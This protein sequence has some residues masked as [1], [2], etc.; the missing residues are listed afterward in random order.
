MTI[1]Q[2]NAELLRELSIIAE[3]EGMLK[4]VLTFVKTLTPAKKTKVVASTKK[5]YKT[6]PVS[7]DIR[8]WSGCAS[9]TEDEIESAPRLKALLSR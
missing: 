5:P 4:K 8:K 2:L 7:S 6:I 1:L 9:F 3:D